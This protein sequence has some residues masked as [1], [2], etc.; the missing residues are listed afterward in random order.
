MNKP[1]MY[2]A[3]PPPW[4]STVLPTEPVAALMAWVAI[5]V[6]CATCVVQPYGRKHVRARAEWW[7]L[8]AIDICCLGSNVIELQSGCNRT[9]IKCARRRTSWTYITLPRAGGGGRTAIPYNMANCLGVWIFHEE[10]PNRL[11]NNLPLNNANLFLCNKD[12]API[13]MTAR[14]PGRLGHRTKISR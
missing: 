3:P 2:S 10:T 6:I 9:K 11:R 7:G 8:D 14:R 13:I 4:V 5:A 1:N 12:T